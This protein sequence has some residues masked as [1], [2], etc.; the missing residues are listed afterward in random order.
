MTFRVAA[1]ILPVFLILLVACG[2]A[3]LRKERGPQGAAAAQA[4]EASTDS[5]TPEEQRDAL[6]REITHLSERAASPE[7]TD[8]EFGRLQRR[9]DTALRRY[10]SAPETI[11]EDFE[12]ITA[13]ERMCDIALA[14]ALDANTA[15]EGPVPDASSAPLEELLRVTTFLS[16]EDLQATY[17]AARKAM[18]EGEPDFPVEMNDVVLSYVN[19]YQNKLRDWFQTALD[20]GSKVFPR[21]KEIFRE[22]GVPT[23]LVYLS[24]VESACNPRAYSRARAAG[25]WQFIAGT[26]R[27][28]GLKVGF[29]EDERWDPE[30][31]AR[32]SAKYLKD[33]HDRFGDWSLALAAYNCG[34]GRILRGRKRYP[35]ADF[36]TL[37][38][39]RYL[40]RETRE[41]VPAIHAA[42]LVAS[43]PAAYGFTIPEPPEAEITTRIE[44]DGPT[45]LRVLA[46]CAG[47]TLEELRDLNPALRRQ[48]TPPRAYPLRIPARV[49]E[50][51][52]A[53]WAEVPEK[54]RLSVAMY[55]VKRGDTLSGIARR[56]GASVE[57]IRL[58][59]RIR[60][61]WIHPGQNLVVPLGSGAPDPSLFSEV[62]PRS[63]GGRSE[64]YRVRRGDTLAKIS[65]RTG[66]SIGRLRRLN[67][68]QGDLIR[69]GQRLSLGR[70]APSRSSVKR[71]WGKGG[72]H[73]VRPGDT[74]WDIARHYGTSVKNLCDVNGI[75]RRSTLR[76]GQVLKVPS[77][78]VIDGGGKTSGEKKWK[79]TFGPTHTVLYGENLW[80]IARKYDTTVETICNVNGFSRGK[81]IQPGDVIRLPSSASTAAKKAPVTRRAEG[82]SEKG[83]RYRV[84]SGDN[85]WTIARRNDT[86]VD[87]I[88]RKNGISR[89]SKLRPGQI[90]LLPD[91]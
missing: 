15:G 16:P 5:L 57:A 48:A 51:F 17:E 2:G 45:D 26:A 87:K 35:Q 79:P 88:C 80:L 73:K 64:T 7:L 84:R 49:R 41:Y 40:V 21:V 25:M 30:R 10:L 81:V 4:P 43:N 46:K 55:T 24:I 22:E 56:F 65:R 37:R 63:G 90:L 19:S 23:S 39:R 78:P 18:G 85:L 1:R 3:A 32:A 58:A 14:L 28:Y 61:H 36:W 62:S 60:S 20:R 74:L 70:P 27:R 72:R 11:R 29:W 59:N 12:I 9:M 6:L 31:S 54:E 42:I 76:L 75:S 52:E 71:S 68:L 50:S 38:K 53:A 69:P 67:G 47:I 82:E 77:G 13:L 44:V 33:L 91:S 86:T 66:V 34:E 8:E 89:Q 83:R